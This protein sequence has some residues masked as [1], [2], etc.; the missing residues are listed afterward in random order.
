[1]TKTADPSEQTAQALVARAL[2]LTESE[3][4]VVAAALLGSLEG[5]AD[6]ASDDEWLAE[7]QRRADSVRSGQPGSLHWTAVRE[8]LLVEVRRN[9]P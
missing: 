9:R 5:P 7:I 3:R 1:M 8:D 6:D 4:V 2:R